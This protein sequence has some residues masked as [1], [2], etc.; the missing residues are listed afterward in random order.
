M[1]LKEWALVVAAAALVAGCGEKGEDGPP[2]LEGKDATLVAQADCGEDGVANVRVKYGQIDE[3]RLIGRNA[4]TRTFGKG[5]D[6]FDSRYGSDGTP[7]LFAIT[8]DPTTGTCTTTLTN[9]DNGEVLA[10]KK[11]AGR[12]ELS[13]QFTG[14]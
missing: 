6:K 12:V 1:K 14:A 7:D 8:T 3:S 11:S 13:V 2:K 10:E 4:V 9:G 5:S